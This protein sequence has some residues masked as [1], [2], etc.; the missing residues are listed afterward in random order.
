MKSKGLFSVAAVFIAMA[1]LAGCGKTAATNT[2]S[3][4]NTAGVS[5]TGGSDSTSAT[6]ATG[7]KKLKKI[8]VAY[9]G[10]TCEAP[11]FV[12]YHNGIFKEEG[13]DVNFVQM[14]FEDLKSGLASGKVSGTVGN[15]AW[16]KPIEQGLQIKITGG[17][18]AGCI[19]AVAPPDSGIASIADL[20]GKTIGVDA[21]GGGP[22][23]ILS[24]ELKKK[25][26]DPKTDVQW[27][28]YPPAQL[29]AAIDKKEIQ[30]FIVWDPFGADLVKNKKYVQL[31]GNGSDEPYKSGYCCYSVVSNKLVENDPEAA[32]AFTRAVLRAAEW[33][34][35]H[36]REA[37]Q[38]EVDQKYVA[39]SVD[40]DEEFIKQY[41]WKPGVKDAAKDV[42]FF[43]EQ[44]KDQGILDPST[45]VNELFKN[46]FY[47]AIPDY[48]GK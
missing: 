18:H 45:D 4:A 22:M 1:L 31:L 25:G 44:T 16:F 13:L 37:A 33:V 15:F 27:K 8:T 11:A 9:A 5:T 29:E 20:K 19:N 34:G 43:I 17:L 23:I 21:I 14:G 30:A 47:Y 28:A 7:E 39:I 41:V 36:T 6:V 35:L 42:K 40:E 24:I 26:I 12:A 38:L 48:N 3:T 46:A 10:G 2:A 32:A